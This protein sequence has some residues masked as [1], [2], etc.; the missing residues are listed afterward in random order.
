MKREEFDRWLDDFEKAFPSLKSWAYKLDDPAATIEFWFKTLKPYDLAWAARVTDL[1][2]SGKVEPIRPTEFGY[3]GI[4]I[5]ARIQR[6]ID[7][8]NQAN[9]FVKAEEFEGINFDGDM[10]NGLKHANA[11]YTLCREAGKDIK[12]GELLAHHAVI[13]C[14]RPTHSER[15]EAMGIFDYHG[16]PWD[17]VEQQAQC[18]KVPGF[19]RTAV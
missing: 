6:Q 11:C 1:M 10:L 8:K 7:Q 2:I 15:D 12:D 3:F 5:R 16:I 18:E 17:S 9:R 19:V 4:E 14:D 13:M